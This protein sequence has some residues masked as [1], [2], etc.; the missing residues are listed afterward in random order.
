MTNPEPDCMPERSDKITELPHRR[1]ANRLLGVLGAL[2]PS[3]RDALQSQ[4]QLVHLPSG[5]VICE[6]GDH[7]DHIYLPTTTV[8][9]LQYVL[10]D[11]MMLE[12]AEVG[13][14]GLFG[15]H[16]IGNNS[17]TPYRAVTSHDGF[18][19]RLGVDAFLKVLSGSADLRNLVLRC[20]QF[21]MAQIAQVSFCSRHH[22]L[23]KQLCRWLIL[24]YDRSRSVEIKVT[25]SVLA[26]MLGV[27]RETISDAAGDLQKMGLIHQHRS[28]I[29]L[30]DLHGLDAQ[31]CGCHR[32]I[33]QEMSRIFPDSVGSVMGLRLGEDRPIRGI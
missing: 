7:F 19:Y 14:E 25:H 8:I 6:P 24:A 33:R 27:W 13:S 11:G 17:A 5:Q 23:K 3:Q 1:D 32:T 18:S 28:S 4:L 9:S 16:L 21:L 15:Q 2:H 29:I 10:S 30:A 26:Q 20:I 31:A 22:L 12:V